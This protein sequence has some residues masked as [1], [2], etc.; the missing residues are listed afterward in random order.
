MRRL[1]GFFIDP[2]FAAA[3][4]SALLLFSGAVVLLVLWTLISG[5]SPF[6]AFE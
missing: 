4:T 5:R 3:M 6:H 2:R 1:L